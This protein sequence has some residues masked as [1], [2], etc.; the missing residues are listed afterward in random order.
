[1]K[2]IGSLCCVDEIQ[3]HMAVFKIL[4]YIHYLFYLPINRVKV[5]VG[6][7][8]GLGLGS[9]LGLGRIR[10]RVRVMFW[11]YSASRR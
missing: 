2:K 1:M 5:R 9:G 10:V 11:V 6:V 8:V 3:V 7:I 4:F